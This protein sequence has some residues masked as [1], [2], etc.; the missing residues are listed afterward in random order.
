MSY[1]QKQSQPN[2][3]WLWTGATNHDYG[4]FYLEGEYVRTHRAI[5]EHCFGVIGDSKWEVCHECDTPLCV[6]PAHLF[7]ATHQGNA[8]DMVSK[9]RC[10]AAKLTPDEVR[11][12]KQL[13]ANGAKSQN[14]RKQF[15]ISQV[16]MWRLKNGQAWKEVN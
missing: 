2:G 1:V 4:T 5:Y 12:I 13:L 6:N 7:T 11:Q 8:L 10:G 9:G 16:Q 3:C 15:G 14:V